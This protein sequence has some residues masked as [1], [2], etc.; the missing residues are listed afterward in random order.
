M[1]RPPNKDEPVSFQLI[2]S[3]AREALSDDGQD[4]RR[5]KVLFL[6]EKLTQ[7]QDL[8]TMFFDVFGGFF[9]TFSEELLDFLLHFPAFDHRVGAGAG[10]EEGESFPTGRIPHHIN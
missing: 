3:L 2:Y 8:R 7:G 1:K 6:K 5:L 10:P 9:F 4:L